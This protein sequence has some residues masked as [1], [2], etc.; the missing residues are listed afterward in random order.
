MNFDQFKLQDAYHYAIA[1]AVLK[2]DVLGE[3]S[4]PASCEDLPRTT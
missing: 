2:G 3:D 1:A 4:S